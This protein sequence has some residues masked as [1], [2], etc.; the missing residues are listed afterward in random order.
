MPKKKKL[1]LNLKQK[2]KPYFRNASKKISC[3]QI[4]NF[5][6][7]IVLYTLNYYSSMLIQ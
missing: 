2:I 7:L 4:Y 1:R 6:F 3:T 5:K